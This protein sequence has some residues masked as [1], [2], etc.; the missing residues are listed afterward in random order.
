MRPLMFFIFYDRYPLPLIF[1]LLSGFSPWTRSP[2]S[3]VA[4]TTHFY[5]AAKGRRFSESQD[6]IS[7]GS[8]LFFPHNKLHNCRSNHCKSPPNILFKG[9]ME[10]DTPDGSLCSCKVVCFLSVLQVLEVEL[11]LGAAPSVT[12]LSCDWG[13]GCWWWDRGRELFSSVEKPALLQ[14]RV[15]NVSFFLRVFSNKP[16]LLK[17]NNFQA[18]K[19]QKVFKR[20]CVCSLTPPGS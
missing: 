11:P 18:T 1:V 17:E 2:T 4:K 9:N 3:S 13:R 7:N 16:V 20:S 15:S 5:Q 14:V 10:P 12:A 6:N 19:N 8:S